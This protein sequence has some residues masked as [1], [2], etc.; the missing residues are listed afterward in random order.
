MKDSEDKLVPVR[1][2]YIFSS[3]DLVDFHFYISTQVPLL[4]KTKGNS[5]GRGFRRYDSKLNQVI[6]RHYSIERANAGKS[7]KKVCTI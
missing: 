1:H 2:F 4:T 3:P 6:N 5:P 7:V